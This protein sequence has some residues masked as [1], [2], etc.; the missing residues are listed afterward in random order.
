MLKNLPKHK[1]GKKIC[2]TWNA[3]AD[4]AFLKL[5]R[6]ITDIVS[7]QLAVWDKDFVLSPD[8]SNWAVG[9][10][11]Q[12]EGPD[13]GL[14]PLAFFS[15][16]LSDSRLN[17]SPPENECY[18]IVAGLLKW[19]GWVGTK[20]LEVRTDHRSP[21]NWATEDLKTVWGPSPRQARWHELFPK[22][23]L[24]VVYTPGPVNPVG[25][26]LSCR[27][28]PAT[29]ALGN[30]SIHGK[31]Q[32]A[33]DV[34]DMMAAEKGQLLTRP[35]AFRAVVAPVVTRSKAAPR[36]IGAPACDP[37]PLASAQGG[38]GGKAREKTSET[39]ANCQD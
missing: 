33:G 17:W 13:G 22:F 26:F 21:E 14:R 23:D 20:Q 19:H 4:Q 30:V 18:A 8:A 5:R 29:P 2:L 32:G 16:K 35:L 31:A 11:L 3:S 24:H 10:A 27:A 28:Y 34:Q 6:V 15:R 9:A 39:G 12:Q 38:G 25:D 1:N 7:L 36:A 37:P